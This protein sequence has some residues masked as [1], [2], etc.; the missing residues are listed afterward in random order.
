MIKDRA[1]EGEREK[2]REGGG[3]RDS[4]RGER[5]VCRTDFRFEP[6]RRWAH[7][8]ILKTKAFNNPNEK[9]DGMNNGLISKQ[10]LIVSYVTLQASK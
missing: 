6:S 8:V 10:Y 3:E 4:F 1:Q 9:L 5:T 7:P 2:G